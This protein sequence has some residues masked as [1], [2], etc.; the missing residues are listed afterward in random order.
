MVFITIT[1]FRRNYVKYIDLS[2]RTRVMVK[3]GKRIFEILPEEKITDSGHYNPQFLDKVAA[4]E[5]SIEEDGG[6]TLTSQDIARI[7]GV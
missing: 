5:R 4:A 2:A 6:K 3:A 1:E 7:L